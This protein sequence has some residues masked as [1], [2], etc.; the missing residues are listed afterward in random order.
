MGELTH[1]LLPYLRRLPLTFP[2]LFFLFLAFVVSELQSQLC[3]SRDLVWVKKVQ[4][5]VEVFQM[6]QAVKI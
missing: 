5:A 1:G 4:L 6:R 2:K 3:S